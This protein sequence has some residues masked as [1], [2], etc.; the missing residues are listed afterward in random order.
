MLKVEEDIKE[1]LD[2]SFLNFARV[3]TVIKSKF[4]MMPRVAFNGGTI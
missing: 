4:V 3:H 1:E 2:V